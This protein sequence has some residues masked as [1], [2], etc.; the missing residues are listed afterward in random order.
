MVEVDLETGEQFILTESCT[1]LRYLV[2]SRGLADHWYPKDLRQ[3]AKVDNYFDW[4]HNNLR[5]GAGGLIFR[6]LF[7]PMISG[8][9]VPKEALEFNEFYLVKSL[10]IM[11]KTLTDNA[12]LCGDQIT[13]A[14]IQASHE[15][16]Q[17]KFLDFD[18]AGKYPH[19]AA[20][21]HK[22]IDENPHMLSHASKMRA[23][24]AA[25]VRKQK[26]KSASAK[27]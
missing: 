17:L 15:V 26:K 25:N 24:A 13:I 16:D 2:A 20:W 1:I 12:Y 4:H 8:K 5:Q 3:R 11:E 19:V 14:D 7:L 23:L 6:K 21:L 9:V 22:V 27:L 18:L 10:K